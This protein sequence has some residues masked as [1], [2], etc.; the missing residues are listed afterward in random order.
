MEL[1]GKADDL[2]DVHLDILDFHVSFVLGDLVGR[3][4]EASEAQ[5]KGRSAPEAYEIQ[6][7]G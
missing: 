6:A 1:D 5:L 4:S 3:S 2:V 7:A